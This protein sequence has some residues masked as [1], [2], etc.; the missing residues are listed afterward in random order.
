MRRKLHYN[1]S[2]KLSTT[3]IQKWRP[4][5]FRPDVVVMPFRIFPVACTYPR[6]HGNCGNSQSNTAIDFVNG[7]QEALT[8]LLYLIYK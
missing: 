1:R 6:K 4:I 5:I 2:E 3:N 7:T 8:T